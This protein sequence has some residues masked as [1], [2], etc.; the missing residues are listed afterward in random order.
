MWKRIL[1]ALV[2]LPSLLAGTALIFLMTLTF[3]DV[4][5]RSVFNNPVVA[6]TELTRISI[7]VVVFTTLPMVAARRQQIVVDL[8]DGLYTEKW[9]RVRDGIIDIVCGLLLYWPISRIVVLGE[10]AFKYGDVTEYLR[11]PQAYVVYFVLAATIVTAA[12]MVIRGG[13]SLFGFHSLRETPGSAI[14]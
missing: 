5:L 6:A 3:T 4:V 11:I 10:R 1:R 2:Q 8:L 14:Q 7:A 9:A 12:V 13:I